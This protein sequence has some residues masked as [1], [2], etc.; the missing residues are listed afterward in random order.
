MRS[1]YIRQ[2]FCSREYV[3]NLACVHLCKAL[4][5]FKDTVC[6]QAEAQNYGISATA[7]VFVNKSGAHSIRWFSP[8]CEIQFCGHA[9]LAAADVLIS[10]LNTC[11]DRLYFES[12]NRI[13]CVTRQGAGNYMM[14]V[15]LSELKVSKPSKVLLSLF[16]KQLTH[17]KETES[18]D[19][20]LV[21][22]LPTKKS[23][24]DF[25]FN[26]LK[27]SQ[28]TRRA[29]IVTSCEPHNSRCLY[30]RYFAPQY[31]VREDPATGSAAPILAAFWQ[32]QPHQIYSCHQLSA[33]GAFYQILQRD[34][35]LCVVA[36]VSVPSQHSAL[37]NI[38]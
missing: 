3:G 26:E 33:Q 22:R 34:N 14:H 36:D 9:T 35:D 17:F 8:H 6:L 32:L 2:V 29:L 27:Y 10:I 12:S 4:S 13:I 15:S 1:H 25:D 16:G 38:K 23:V 31:G 18:S 21:A 20:Y 7:F 30:F 28:L 5:E 24:A 19:G 37:C 11:Q